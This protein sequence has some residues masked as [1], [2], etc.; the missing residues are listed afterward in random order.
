MVPS[1]SVRPRGTMPGPDN[2]F[3]VGVARAGTAQRRKADEPSPRTPRPPRR[4]RPDRRC[5]SDAC[6]RTAETHPFDAV[7]WEMRDARIGHG[8]R[9]AFEQTRRRV[10][11]ELVAE[12]DEHRRPEVL[13]RAAR[14][15][16]ARALGQ[17]DDRPRRRHDHRL[18][19]RAR[20][21][22]QR[23]GR[24]GLRGRADPHPAAPD[25]GVQ[26]AR[27]VQR[28]LRGEPAVLAPASSS[29]SRTRWSRSS[30]GT[31]RRG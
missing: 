31:P 30:T 13:P 10:P 29:P 6:S 9:I 22:R 23:R 8:D 7:E 17:A 16:R 2:S 1:R 26:L 20:L 4:R 28:R 21:L 15:P 19:R 18:G 3:R 14:Q 12:R 27:L 24:A 25:G 5:R 11:Q